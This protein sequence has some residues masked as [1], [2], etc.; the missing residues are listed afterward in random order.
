MGRTV[1]L[2]HEL[3]DGSA[4]YDWMIQREGPE[5]PGLITFRVSERIDAAGVG[6]FVAQRLPDHREAYLEYEGSVSGGRGRVC[7]VAE[8]LVRLATDSDQEVV[9]SGNLGDAAGRF[10]GRRAADGWRFRFA[11]GRPVFPSRS[12]R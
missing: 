7:R 3:P 8:G 12:A 10:E 4:H 11:K 9:C 1:L 6:E 5:R 2:R